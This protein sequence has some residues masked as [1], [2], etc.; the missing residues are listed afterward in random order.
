MGVKECSKIKKNIVENIN[1]KNVI[2]FRVGQWIKTGSLSVTPN[3]IKEFH[4]K[5]RKK[6]QFYLNVASE[7]AR[8][9]FNIINEACDSDS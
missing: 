5:M 4:Q 9:P 8:N 7:K 1:P 3:I 6:L 2:F